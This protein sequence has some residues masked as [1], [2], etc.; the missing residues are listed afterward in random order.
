MRPALHRVLHPQ[1]ATAHTQTPVDFSY[2]PPEQEAV[3]RRL[4]NW[5]RWVRVRPPC[6]AVHP[7]WR[8][9][10]SSRQWDTHPQT[11]TEV[12][13]VD[14]QRLECAVAVLPD[15]QRS[16]LRWY[17]MH[18]AGPAVAARSLSVTT[19]GLSDLVKAG[20][21]AVLRVVGL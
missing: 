18:S 17:Y 10:L 14:A 11:R 3:H 7:M 16:A 1:R 2:V 9:V 12:D 20:R 5:A 4:E 8:Q 15:K 19:A 21:A 13:L 6:G